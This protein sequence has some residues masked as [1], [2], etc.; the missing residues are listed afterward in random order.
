MII[1]TCTDNTMVWDLEIAKVFD[2][3]VKIEPLSTQQEKEMVLKTKKVEDSMN[4]A[5]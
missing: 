4:L 2:I 3:R 5:R 1:G